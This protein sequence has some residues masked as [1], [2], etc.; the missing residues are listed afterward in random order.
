MSA[1]HAGGT[2][3]THFELLAAARS[4]VKWLLDL[5]NSDGGIPTFCRG[6]G[7][8][9]FDRSS[10]DLTAHALRAWSAWSGV[11]GEYPHELAA[12]RRGCARALKYLD[13]SR[14]PDGS[15]SPLWFGNQLSASQENLTYGTARVV[16]ALADM[17]QGSSPSL[18]DEPQVQ[19]SEPIFQRSLEWLLR[20]QN[21]DGS[22]GGAPGVAGSIEETALA[23]EAL[24]VC[25]GSIQGWHGDVVSGVAVSVPQDAK[26]Q[27]GL[28]VGLPV[29]AVGRLRVKSLDNQTSIDEQCNSRI[30]NAAL[31]GAGWL[32]ERTQGGTYFPPSPIGLYFARLWY[33]ESLYPVI[34]TVAALGRLLKVVVR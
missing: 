26:Q 9:P 15:W 2:P 23:V 25:C 3:A 27:A 17:M 8:L 31:R 30:M 14:R 1:T 5:Q 6:W 4:G 20:A 18:V 33:H 13:T 28:P 21:S 29:G 34:F 32:I 12:V 10:P 11:L 24:A 7:K 16:Q 19:T 22:W